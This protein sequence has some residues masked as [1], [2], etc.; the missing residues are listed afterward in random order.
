MNL[1]NKSIAGLTAIALTVSGILPVANVAQAAGWEQNAFDRNADLDPRITN[2]DSVSALQKLSTREEAIAFLSRFIEN[3]DFGLTFDASA[4]CDYTD[5][6]NIMS[7]LTDEVMAACEAGIIKSATTNPMVNA[8]ALVTEGQFAMMIA[9]TVTGEPMELAEANAFLSDPDVMAYP[10]TSYK[11]DNSLSKILAL[12]MLRKL[13]LS[14]E[15]PVVDCTIDPTMPQCLPS[16][17]GTVNTG[18]VLNP[19][20]N[21]NLS[22]GVSATS[23]AA[24]QIASKGNNVKVLSLDLTAG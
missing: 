21:G 14:L 9:R 23:P 12:E 8:K 20:S 18:T 1:F 15:E 17:T 3:Y 7:D 24:K 2:A 16:T 19:V 10:Y 22:V 6:A 4:N 13:A 11:G 5:A